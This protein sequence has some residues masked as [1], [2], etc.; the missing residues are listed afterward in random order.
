MEKEQELQE[1]RR[2]LWEEVE[3]YDLTWEPDCDKLA[4]KLYE[5]GWRKQQ[6][7]VWLERRWTTEDDWGYFH[8]I[9][10]ECSVCK[11]EIYTGEPTKYC[12]HCGAEMQEKIGRK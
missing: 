10:I 2:Y 8:H 3:G 6:K 4:E 1:I 11:T 9:S 12:P 7:G 5:D